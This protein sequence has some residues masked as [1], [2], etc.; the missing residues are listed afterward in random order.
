MTVI[1][2]RQEI[3][4]DVIDVAFGGKGLAKPEGFSIFVDGAVAGDRVRARISKKKKNYAE[5]RVLEILEPSK[6]RVEAPCAYSDYCGGCKWQYLDYDRQLAYKTQHVEEA[7]GHIAG[8]EGVT[9]H[10]ALPSPKV[11]HYR[12]KMEFSC[13]DRRWLMPHELNDESIEAGFGIGLHVPGTFSK[14]IDIDFCHIQ[15]EAGNPILEFMRN[16][17]KESDLPVYGLKSH[18]G[19]WRFVMLRHSV[20]DDCW[21]VNIITKERNDGVLKPLAEALM[22]KFPEVSC[23]VNN[24]TARKAGIAFG[25]YEVHL[26]GD[27]HISDCLGPYRFKIS[28]NS[29]FQTNTRGAEALYGKVAE[30]ANLS[31]DETVLDLYS[32]TGTIPIWLSSHAKEILG[33]E[34]VESAVKDAKLNCEANGI[35]NCKFLLGDMKDVLPTIETIPDVMI[36]DPPRAGMHKDVVA[37]ILEVMPE[38]IVYVS[39]NPAT[40]ARDLEMMKDAYQVEEVQPVDMFPHTFH[41]EAVARL[42]RKAQG[43]A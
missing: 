12:N 40:M 13:S 38:R 31:G 4:L 5:A 27:T 28:A 21:M 42:T 7:L 8:I 37:R 43:G 22:A 24:V 32:G 29:F 3:E 36:I 23:V 14:V 6:D 35:T 17:I 19:F 1:K 11:F 34:I 25:E 41:I 26:A 15:A 18:E 20:A 2:K 16:A 9:V 39:C 30:Y 10:P 33:I